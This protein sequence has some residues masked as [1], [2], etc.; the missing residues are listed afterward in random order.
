MIE[1]NFTTPKDLYNAKKVDRDLSYPFIEDFFIVCDVGGA[2]GVDTFP[3]AKLASFTIDLDVDLSSLKIGKNHADEIGISRKIFFIGASASDLPF[4]SNIL[5]MI[6]CFSVLDHLPGKKSAQRAISEF[7]RVI[8]FKGY[9]TIT[10]PNK[11]F[12]FGTLLMRIKK[13]TDE[14]AYFEQRFTPKEF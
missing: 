13:Y 3:I 9:I 8:R 14:D 5:N 11:L 12:L 6:T 2:S 7:S 1:C 10:V 4:R